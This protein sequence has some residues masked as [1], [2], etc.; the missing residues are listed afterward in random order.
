MLN[1]IREDEFIELPIG[2]ENT[3]LAEIILVQCAFFEFTKKIFNKKLMVAKNNASLLS[4]FYIDNEKLPLLMNQIDVRHL[5]PKNFK[6]LDRKKEI[7]NLLE[8]LTNYN[9]YLLSGDFVEHD[10]STNYRFHDKFIYCLLYE[11]TLESDPNIRL[12]HALQREIPI[13]YS[14]EKFELA[15]RFLFV[16]AFLE[17]FSKT[18]GCISSKTLE[19]ADSFSI[20][21]RIVTFVK[22]F[23]TDLYYYRIESLINYWRKNRDLFPDSVEVKFDELTDIFFKKIIRVQTEFTTNVFDKPGDMIIKIKNISD[24]S[25]GSIIAENISWTPIDGLVEIG[26]KRK[27]R[28]KFLAP[29][30]EYT[31]TI[32]I[33][34]KKEGTINFRNLMI[35]FNDPFGIKHYTSL[36]LPALKIKKK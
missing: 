29:K 31:L 35:R 17:I 13:L 12:A 23:V 25:L 3:D 14:E 8:I 19:I 11:F 5:L 33:I 2:I 34:P 6:Q 28:A 15:A 7:P 4:L 26:E 36:E 24:A 9:N 21:L 1:Y 27:I 10:F 18:N 32:P 16:T 20:D 30:E 22:R